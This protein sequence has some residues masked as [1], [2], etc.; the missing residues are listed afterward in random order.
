MGMATTMMPA[1]VLLIFWAKRRD[2]RKQ[3]GRGWR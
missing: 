3:Q 1:I 2:L